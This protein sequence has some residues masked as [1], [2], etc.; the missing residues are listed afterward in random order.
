MVASLRQA[1]GKTSDLERLLHCLARDDSGSP[2]QG[3][4][5]ALGGGEP[6]SLDARCQ[7]QRGCLHGQERQCAKNPLVDPPGGAQHDQPGHDT[8]RLCQE[9]TQQAT[10]AKIRQ[11]SAPDIAARLASTITSGRSR[12]VRP[13]TFGCGT[14][15][16]CSISSPALCLRSSRT[17]QGQQNRKTKRLR[18]SVR[19]V[20]ERFALRRDTDLTG[21]KVKHLPSV[22]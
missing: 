10:E 20:T 6:A 2:G 18:A 21:G 22:R 8:A 1:G 11:P 17:C 4:A 12:S 5:G 7:F 19:F 9:E 13:S 15:R 16:N 3:R 14:S